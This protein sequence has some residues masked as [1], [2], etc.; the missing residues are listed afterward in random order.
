MNVF[1]CYSIYT[2]MGVRTMEPGNWYA[3]MNS[4]MDPRAMQVMMAPAN[5]A[6]HSNRMNTTMNPQTYKSMGN[7]VNM[8]PS[9]AQIAP[10]TNTADTSTFNFV[11]PNA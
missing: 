11:D 7:S 2:Q 1:P 10:A 5:P 4:M 8:V 6:L 3:M 9:A